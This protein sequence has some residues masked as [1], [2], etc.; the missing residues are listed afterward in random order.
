M[1]AVTSVD[2]PIALEGA[3]AVVTGGAG[4]IGRGIVG[5]LLRHG[6]S[7]AIADV[8]ADAVTAAVEDLGKLGPVSGHQV[9]SG[10]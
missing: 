1:E 2:E 5:A 4:G 6:A 3:V 8:E 7:V 10:G 9:I